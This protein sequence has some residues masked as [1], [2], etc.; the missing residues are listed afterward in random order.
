MRN[1]DKTKRVLGRGLSELISASALAVDIPGQQK[2]NSE[3]SKKIPIELIKPNK[4]QPRK[5]FSKTALEELSK[6]IAAKGVIQPL[7]VRKADEAI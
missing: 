5:K 3:N 7:L 1:K 4:N 6:S 2:D